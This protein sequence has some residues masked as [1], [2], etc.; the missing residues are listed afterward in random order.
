MTPQTV[1]TKTAKGILE[2]RNK[3]TRLPRDLLGVLEIIDGNA[4]VADLQQ[5]SG[6]GE[7]QMHH[8]LT[9]L[10]NDGYAKTVAP[11]SAAAERDPAAVQYESPSEL[12]RLNMEL[13]VHALAGAEAAKVAQEEGRAALE[14]RL[15]ADAEA[16]ARALAE[17]RLASEKEARA[18]SEAAARA[19][20]HARAHAEQAAAAATDAASRA[21]AQSEAR[22]AATAAL[23]ARAEAQARAEAEERAR[24]LVDQKEAAEQ[25]AREEALAHG[26]A[27]SRAQERAAAETRA[28]DALQAQIDAANA[29]RSGDDPEARARLHE[30]EAA[31]ERARAE[32]QALAEA[33]GV[34][35]ELPTEHLHFDDLAQKLTARANAERRAREEAGRKARAGGDDAAAG[36]APGRN[37]DGFPPLEFVSPAAEPQAPPNQSSA[38]LPDIDTRASAGRG[39]QKHTTPEH[40]PSALE[41]AMMEREARTEAEA[42]NTGAPSAVPVTRG[43]ATH[44][45]TARAPAPAYEATR[46]SA[47]PAGEIGQSAPAAGISAAPSLADDGPV[48][49]R[50]NVDRAAHD[51]IAENAEHQRNAEV[52]ALSRQALDLRRQRQAEEARRL[53]REEREAK[54]RKLVRSA[55][56]VAIALPLLGIAWLQFVPLDGYVP[57]VQ[58]ALTTRFNQP[59]TVSKVR[60]VLL[61]TPRIVLERVRIGSAQA[62]HIDRV[63]AHAWPGALLATPM[64]FDLVEAS[65]VTV[66]PG[67]V[68]A[69][70]AWTGGRSAEAVHVSRLKLRDVQLAT[71]AE[72]TPG[73]NGQVEFAANGT[74]TGANLSNENV[75]LEVVPKASGLIVSLNAHGWRV[76]FGPPVTFTYLTVEG[77]ADKDRFATTRL[78]ARLGGGEIGGT[79]AARWDDATTVGGELDIRGARIDDAVAE[80]APGFRAKGVLTAKL[81]YAAQ[82]ATMT[83]LMRRPLVDGTFKLTRGE[84]GGV[85]LARAVQLPGTPTGG[86]TVFEEL[87]GSVQIDG[88]RYTYRDLHLTSGPLE[89]SGSIDVAPGGRLSGRVDAQITARSTVA[90]RAAF[91]VRGTVKEPRLSR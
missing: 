22:E 30:I 23:R 5:R 87:T 86:R 45:P 6:L 76:P 1:F 48:E 65:G 13:A 47:P 80:L 57:E 62:V 91:A 11:P 36:A 74:V 78:D 9:T 70:P 63:D 19:A 26:E 90:A 3:S 2:I 37:N 43:T 52:A 18:V 68:A 39:D 32:A 21:A 73:L 59:A 55:V 89:A 84:L 58:E 64:E 56:G 15:R 40:V 12:S 60:Y 54:R 42:R 53:A 50:L 16:R 41:R 17:T 49:E 71:N 75:N 35:A 20:Q 7:A 29:V 28:R 77:I 44:A 83:G 82:A 8:A 61:P 88:D 31:A 67:I 10:A 25:R 27:E 69:F 46:A 14:A 33:Q 85:D 72:K 81:R 24:A 51:L 4:S 66:D 34:A 79:L 38:S